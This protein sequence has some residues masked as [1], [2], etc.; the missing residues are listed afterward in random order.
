MISAPGSSAY[1]VTI[2]RRAAVRPIAGPI[3]E[4]TPTRRTRSMIASHCSRG[5]KPAM[6]PVA[7]HQYH[8]L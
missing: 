6:P 4:V 7:A 1:R 8:A 3:R 2:V 5:D